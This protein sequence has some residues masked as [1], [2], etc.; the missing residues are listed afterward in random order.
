MN[1]LI[2]CILLFIAIALTGGCLD[3]TS[4]DDKPKEATEQ[5]LTDEVQYVGQIDSGSI[6]VKDIDEQSGNYV[7][8]V[9]RFSD[10]VRNEFSSYT[11]KEGD[12]I[13]VKY[14]D[15][16]KGA[17]K[18]YIAYDIE[19]FSKQTERETSKKIEVKVEG[20]TEYRIANLQYSDDRKYSLYVLDDFT[21]SAEEPN[22]DIIFSKTDGEFFV[23][24]EKLGEKANIDLLKEN[25][26]NAYKSMGTVN[27]RDPATI[28]AEKFKD[29]KLWLQVD[30]AK[31]DSIKTQTTINYLVKSY[32]NNNYAF[33][34]HFP[35][36]E[37][38]EGITPA[39]WAMVSTME[40]E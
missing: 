7:Y 22:K 1:K 14:K 9:F 6:E 26:I 25:F 17:S 10:K 16:T 2:I 39:L 31:S 19:K 36:K 20:N 3:Q 34:F 37:A 35:L 18:A 23:R 13:R 8:K 30:I 40:V 11:L 15:D 29:S 24:I 12:F 28:F 5:F 21:F 32:G 33:V 27:E 38:M 4:K